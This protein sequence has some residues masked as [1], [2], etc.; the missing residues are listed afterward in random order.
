MFYMCKSKSTCNVICLLLAFV[1]SIICAGLRTLVTFDCGFI[2]IQQNDHDYRVWN[3][4]DLD[5]CH[6][7]IDVLYDATIENTANNV[8]L[9]W[10]FEINKNWKLN[11]KIIHHQ[12]LLSS[13]ISFSSSPF[14]TLSMTDSFSVDLSCHWHPY[15]SDAFF[16]QLGSLLHY[17]DYVLLLPIS[18]ISKMKKENLPRW[19]SR[20]IFSIFLVSILLCYLANISLYE[21]YKPMF[22]TEPNN[23]SWKS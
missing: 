20:Y 19:S 10:I 7:S 18:S 16:S 15:S 6:F 17:C 14:W 11:T 5:Y 21:Y 3:Q 2:N 12:T 22:L 9:H 1:L 4:R 13:Q 23:L 8:S